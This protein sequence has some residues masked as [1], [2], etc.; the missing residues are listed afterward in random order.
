MRSSAR[1]LE[2]KNLAKSSQTPGRTQMINFFCWRPNP[3]Q[4]MMFADLPGYGYNVASG[5]T[6]QQWQGLLESGEEGR[7]KRVKEPDSLR[8]LDRSGAPNASILSQRIVKKNSAQIIYLCLKN[9]ES[10]SCLKCQKKK[11]TLKERFKNYREKTSLRTCLLLLRSFY[12]SKA[13]N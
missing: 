11:K 12:K 9:Q 8:A 7:V 10:F 4:E 3:K 2:R 5:R 6:R 1:Y 13:T